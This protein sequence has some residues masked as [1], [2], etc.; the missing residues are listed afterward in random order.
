MVR[1]WFSLN[2]LRSRHPLPTALLGAVLCLLARA[3]PGTLLTAGS[4]AVKYR[5]RG[6][7]VIFGAFPPT[8]RLLFPTLAGFRLQGRTW[9]L[10]GAD[11]TRE[12][13]QKVLL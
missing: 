13:T 12:L 7:Y 11:T 3:L 8:Q 9:G 10:G 1:R 4:N 5:G 6:Q 2:A